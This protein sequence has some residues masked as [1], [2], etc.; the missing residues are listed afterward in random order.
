MYHVVKSHARK[1]I[2]VSTAFAKGVGTVSKYVEEH[3]RN[4]TM[5]RGTVVVYGMLRGLLSVIEAARRNKQDW[6]YLDNGYINP[7]YLDGYYSVTYNAFQHPGTG[8]YERGRERLGKLKLR[9][10]MEQWKTSGNHILI[11]PPTRAFARLVGLDSE[12]WIEDTLKK[13]RMH[14][15]RPIEV[16]RKPGS[17][18]PNGVKIVITKAL[19]DDLEGCHAVVAYNSK[20]CVEAVVRGYPVFVSTKCCAW[21]MGLDDIGEI[22]FPIYEPDR[23]MWLETLAANQFTL[24]EMRT[25]NLVELLDEDR[26]QNLTIPPPLDEKISHFFT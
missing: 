3:K 20:A 4:I 11:F 2:V 26:K 25:R 5:T 8:I 21:G 12:I 22:E 23:R 17:Y 7:G 18:L 14:T 24:E 6:I 16:R 9:W 10:K 13:L 19:A 1:S 15:D